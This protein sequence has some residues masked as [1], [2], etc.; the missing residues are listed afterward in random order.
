[1]SKIITATI[2]FILGIISFVQSCKKKNPSQKLSK[3]AMMRHWMIYFP[4]HKIFIRSRTEMSI[5]VP[6]CIGMLTGIMTS[7]LGGGTSVLIAPILTYLI[8]RSGAVVTGTALLAGFGINGVV[9]ILHSLDHNPPD[10]MLVLILCISGT[11]GSYLGTAISYKLPKI[12]LK[13]AGSFVI[14]FI[15][16][17]FFLEIFPTPH[18]SSKKE[19]ITFAIKP[20]NFLENSN[21]TQS[22]IIEKISEY[23]HDHTF[24]YSIALI[25]ITLTSALI[26]NIIFHLISQKWRY[27][28]EKKRK[29]LEE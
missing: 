29:N 18:L 26:F 21:K 3:G 17:K 8:G 22:P 9:A 2:L 15:A 19:E 5:V 10:F 14:M 28:Q 6:F 1:L 11:I 13:I 20:Q 4:L 12:Y 25:A 24:E 16:I 27:I 7:S 23:A